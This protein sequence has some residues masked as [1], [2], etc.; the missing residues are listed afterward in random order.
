M[1]TKTKN[2]RQNVA[3]EMLRHIEAGTAPW[4]KPWEAGVLGDNQ[5]NPSSNRAYRGINALWLEMQGFEDPRWLTLNQANKMDAK[6]RKGER[7]TQVEYWKWTAPQPKLDE[8]GKPILDDNGKK[9]FGTQRL[10]RP[11]VFYANVFNAAQIDGLEP[12]KA[13]ELTFEPVEEAEKLLAAGGVDILNDQRDRAFYSP[14]HDHICLPSQEQFPD[15]Y[16]YYA[17]ALHELG[18]ATGHSSRMDRQFGPFG[19]EVYAKEELRAEMTSYMVARDLGLGHY[20]ERHASYVE[21]WLKAIKDDRNVLFQAAR[22]AEHMTQWIKEPELRPTLERNAQSKRKVAKMER[23]QKA[24]QAQHI[25]TGYTDEEREQLRTRQ[26]EQFTPPAEE[27]QKSQDAD[28]RSL[29]EDIRRTEVHQLDNG[30]TQVLGFDNED[31]LIYEE[32]HHTSMEA[33]HK[34]ALELTNKHQSNQQSQTESLDLAEERY[35]KS[36]LN[37]QFGQA[38]KEDI[39][40]NRPSAFMDENYKLAHKF[41]AVEEEMGRINYDTSYS[42]EEQERDRNEQYEITEAL[43][44]RLGVDSIHPFLGNTET[45]EKLHDEIGSAIL[46]EQEQANDQQ[47]R[48]ANDVVLKTLTRFYDRGAPS[49]DEYL[50]AEY[51]DLVIDGQREKAELDIRK[52]LHTEQG[53]TFLADAQK[54]GLDPQSAFFD[55]EF[56]TSLKTLGKNHTSAQHI[57][58]VIE[59]KAKNAG[60]EASQQNKT[61]KRVYL[62][63]P[64][65]EK[66]QAKEAGAKW[67]RRQKAWYAP[68]GVDLKPLEKWTPEHQPKQEN[69]AI[70]PRKEFADELKLHGVAIKGEPIMDGKWHRTRLEGDKGKARNASYRAFLDGRPNGQIKNYKIHG[71]GQ[72]HKWVATGE[73][74]TKD[75]LAAL[76]AEAVQK[77]LE[78]NEERKKLQKAAQQTAQERFLKATLQPQHPYLTKKN[79]QNHGLYT[80]DKGNLL[81]PARDVKGDLWSVQAITAKGGKYFQKNA[82][83]TGLMHVI[84]PQNKIGKPGTILFVGE[85]YSTGASVH[86]ATKQP[87]VVAFNGGNL[88]PV[89]EALRKKYPEAEIVIAGDND[90][91]LENKPYGNIGIKKATEAAQAVGGAMVAPHFND[92]QKAKGLTDWNDLANDQGIEAVTKQIRQ[93]MKQ[94][95]QVAKDK[96]REQSQALG[97]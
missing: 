28:E 78:R 45:L 66:D 34:R 39:L 11:Q 24:E 47:R 58:D 73:T 54:N 67:D 49:Q 38:I 2:W 57:L 91:K 5:H 27:L 52:A 84:D 21:S 22:D 95:K 76:K 82:R 86:Q 60:L 15:A 8:H 16:R 35:S 70:D 19:S 13:P 12:Y 41:R 61:A 31:L 25:D 53:K 72:S 94:Q 88:K 9:V 42:D 29:I 32:N 30:K 63:V 44:N 69:K 85:G 83:L 81:V 43:K 50:R 10:E 55:E 75:Q 74:L 51:A 92:A 89:A 1:S 33:A 68:Q 26:G 59:G 14:N 3:E 96:G 48:P 17:T 4:Q 6:I 93:Q 71:E 18:H 23:E 7:S 40:E 36:E 65:A 77:Q 87:S 46:F 62:A 64:Y 20:P 80:N 97:M 56:K 90:H 79:V 37:T